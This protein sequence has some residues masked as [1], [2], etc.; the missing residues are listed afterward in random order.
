M[1]LTQSPETAEAREE[2]AVKEEELREST[3][4]EG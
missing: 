2:T 4:D 1:F 3:F